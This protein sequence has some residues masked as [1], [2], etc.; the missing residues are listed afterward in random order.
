MDIGSV[1]TS[2]IV[3]G[4]SFDIVKSYAQVTSQFLKKAAEG[5]AYE[6]RSGIVNLAT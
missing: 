5:S 2:A 3:G 1:I 6:W 4:F